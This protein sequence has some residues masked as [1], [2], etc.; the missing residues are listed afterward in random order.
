MSAYMCSRQHLATVAQIV[1]HHHILPIIC[2]KNEK[3]TQISS[4][5]EIA[6]I[7]A[8]E[9]A[10]SVNSLYNLKGKDKEKAL[11]NIKREEAVSTN[12]YQSIMV[13]RGYIYQACESPDWEESVAYQLCI[14]AKASITDNILT[15]NMVSLKFWSL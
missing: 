7:L 5:A 3:F 1:H 8:N 6:E 10:S 15:D 4:F 12:L 13:L 2:R 9:N 11:T 14:G